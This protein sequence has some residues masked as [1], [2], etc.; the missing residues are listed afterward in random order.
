MEKIVNM[1]LLIVVTVN[2]GTVAFAAENVDGE[3]IISEKAADV[4]ENITGINDIHT[5]TKGGET[6]YT[7]VRDLTGIEIPQNADNAVI[8][9]IANGET[10]AMNLPKEV[11]G[12]KGVM[13]ENGTVMYN[14]S[15][16]AVSVSVQIIQENQDGI[17]AYGVRSLILIENATAPKEYI[18]N[19]DLPSG[20]RLVKDYDYNDELDAYDCGQ[21]FVINENKEIVSTIDPAWAKDANGNEVAT[22][23]MINGNDLIQFVEFDKNSAFPIVA[24]PTNHPT[25]YKIYYID[26][27]NLQDI[28][29]KGYISCN[30]LGVSAVLYTLE[31][32]PGVNIG[33]TVVNGMMLVADLWSY[34]QFRKVEAKFKI[35]RSNQWLKTTYSYTWRNGGKNSGY[36][37]S[38]TAILE[39]VNQK[40]A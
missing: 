7:A 11:S 2:M 39:I 33:A 4:V 18:F 14:S 31:L 34:A 36:V 37:R 16:E 32:I 17:V 6:T 10:I 23:Y 3:K 15:E 22:H 35:M 38:A 26:Y 40:G 28:I 25:K 8:T 13:T 19:F 24:D 30:T 1:L 12:E 29:D 21:I 27:K 5:N 9:E 20:Y